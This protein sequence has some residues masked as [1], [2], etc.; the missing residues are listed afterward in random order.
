MKELSNG[1]YSA[2][3]YKSIIIGSPPLTLSSPDLS[4]HLKS[5]SDSDDD[6]DDDDDGADKCGNGFSHYQAPTTCQVVFAYII[7]SVL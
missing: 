3:N 6:S 7:S 5:D 1:K 4:P 2:D